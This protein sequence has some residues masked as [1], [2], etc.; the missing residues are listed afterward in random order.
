MLTP[1]KFLSAP[2]S[3]IPQSSNLTTTLHVFTSPAPLCPSPLDTCVISIYTFSG[4]AH[5]PIYT[6]VL[7]MRVLRCYVH[8]A[9]YAL[10]MH[11]PWRKLSVRS[12]KHSPRVG[13][14]MVHP[15]CQS[16]SCMQAPHGVWWVGH[17][18]WPRRRPWLLAVPNLVF[19]SL[20]GVTIF[21]A[22]W[23]LLFNSLFSQESPCNSVITI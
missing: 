16:S 22:S 7:T 12:H 21:H 18:G 4:G 3:L 8:A 19:F 1:T 10:L 11:M 14:Y 20:Q 15:C 5:S 2:L 23:T 9:P 17:S 13:P 6:P